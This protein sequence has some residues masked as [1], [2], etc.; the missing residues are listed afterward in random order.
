MANLLPEKC[1]NCG[2][3]ITHFKQHCEPASLTNTLQPC[4]ANW[5]K[6]DNLRCNLVIDTKTGNWWVEYER[7]KF[8]SGGPGRIAA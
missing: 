4:P 3:N 7:G 5:L 8:K 1:P 6:C 2:R